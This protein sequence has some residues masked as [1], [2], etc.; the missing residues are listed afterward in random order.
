MPVDS[1]DRPDVPAASAGDLPD[2][3][4]AR[5]EE[6]DDSELRAVRSYARALLPEPP[7]VPDLL[8]ERPGE[9]ILEVEEL[10]EY[11]RVVKTQPCVE[12]CDECPHGP[13]LYHVRVEDRPD[14]DPSLHWVFVG[15]VT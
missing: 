1:D 7:T 11:A 9:E 10:D 4:R 12:G 2:D 13:F 14:D 5:L 15:P 3:L 8:E 6:L